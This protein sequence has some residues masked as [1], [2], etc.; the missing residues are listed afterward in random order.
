MSHLAYYQYQAT[1]RGI[2]TIEDV[3]RNASQNA[4]IY[5]RIVLPWLPTNKHARIAELACGHGAFLCWLKERGYSNVEGVDSSAEQTR[6]AS[7]VALVH[8][9]DVVEW[10]R[11][12]KD[13][14][15]STLVAIDFIEH[16]SK[17][18]FMDLLRE[19]SRVLAASGA[20]ILRYP[21]G[22]S[23]MVGFNLF[24][25]ITHIWTYSPGC[26]ETLATMHGFQR[27]DFIDE[28]YNTIRDHRWLKVPL[29]KISTFILKSLFRAATRVKVDYWSPFLWAR[30]TR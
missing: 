8:Q 15:C 20:L 22:S 9:A 28:G 5:D 27:V 26:L 7:Q 11:N 10:L 23:P 14:S 30:L 13:G 6:F 24:A 3:K 18:A 21:N 2:H 16:I 29:G 4:H 19:T 17:D 12:Q 1:A 25:D